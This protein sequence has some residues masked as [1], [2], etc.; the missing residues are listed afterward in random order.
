MVM[1]ISPLEYTSRL[2]PT[3]PNPPG[4]CIHKDV[5]FDDDGSPRSALV[6]HLGIFLLMRRI[7]DFAPGGELFLDDRV[8]SFE[9]H[10]GEPEVAC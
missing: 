10:P 2:Y 1:K 5:A 4:C 7:M 6:K 3:A 9:S 8:L